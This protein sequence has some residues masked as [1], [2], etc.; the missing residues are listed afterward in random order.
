M[1][2]R[3][4]PAVVVA[5][6]ILL[7]GCGEAP[8]TAPTAEP[9]PLGEPTRTVEV[10]PVEAAEFKTFALSLADVEA[11]EKGLAAEN[12]RIL[13]T[14]SEHGSDDVAAYVATLPEQTE[15]AAAE[16]AGVPVEHYR[17]V[18]QT[19]LEVL[20]KVEAQPAPAATAETN[21]ALDPSVAGVQAA[22]DDPYAGIDPVVATALRAAHP[23]L[24]ALRAEHLALLAPAVDQS[25]SSD[26]A[27]SPSR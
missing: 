12:A 17:N 19:I 4:L 11:F 9:S 13:A 10:V 3:V 20:Y 22:L 16:A 7:A 1:R 26:A 2:S 23:R 6:S 14:S 21:S 18:K 8:S 25:A 24:A 15:P 27:S 5:A